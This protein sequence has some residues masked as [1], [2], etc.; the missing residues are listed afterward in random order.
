[1]QLK[2]TAKQ[3]KTKL[4]E[5]MDPELN[6]SIVDL[7]LVYEV[8]ITKNKVH[9]IMTLTTIGCPLFA[10]IEAQVKDKIKELGIN[11]KDVT[12]ELTFD[13][14]WSMEKMSKKGRAMLGI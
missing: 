1:M 9:V 12:L 8:K 10:T 13:P 14:P 5:V 6:I 4:T 7:G 11:E 3:I 2:L